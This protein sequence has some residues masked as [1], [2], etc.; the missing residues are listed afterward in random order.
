MSGAVR[1]H[2]ASQSWAADNVV[3]SEGVRRDQKCKYW[4]NMQSDLKFSSLEW[5][6]VWTENCIFWHFGPAG[7]ELR[8]AL[9][10]YVAPS[11]ME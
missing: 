9:T 3:S 2:E 4:G 1:R 11:L 6:S 8:L 5:C 7:K 10:L